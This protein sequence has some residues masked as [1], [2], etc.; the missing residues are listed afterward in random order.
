MWTMC[1]IFLITPVLVGMK[2]ENLSLIVDNSK[3][4][5]TNNQLEKVC[6]KT[7]FCTGNLIVPAKRS[8][9]IV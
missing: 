9:Y 6:A 2:N 4:T 8:I 5:E 3:T 7:Y 1:I